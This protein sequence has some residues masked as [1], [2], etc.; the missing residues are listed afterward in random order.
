MGPLHVVAGVEFWCVIHMSSMGVIKPAHRCCLCRRVIVQH[1]DSDV[2]FAAFVL[3]FVGV[4]RA[5][6]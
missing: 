6:S 5:R 3:H 1:L 2:D 4:E